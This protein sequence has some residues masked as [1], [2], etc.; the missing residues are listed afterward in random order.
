MKFP[1]A[2]FGLFGVVKSNLKGESNIT[3][4]NLTLHLKEGSAESTPPPPPRPLITALRSLLLVFVSSQLK[5]KRAMSGV[6]SAIGA[7]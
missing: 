7:D 3:N 1:E 6:H 4:C 2:L 5:V